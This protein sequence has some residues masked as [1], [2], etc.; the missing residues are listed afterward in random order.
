MPFTRKHM[1]EASRLG[2]LLDNFSMISTPGVPTDAPVDSADLYAALDMYAGT[3]KPLVLLI[4]GDGKLE[5]VIE[6]LSALHGD[7]S[8]KP[9]C[10]PYVNPITPLVLNRTT[11]DKMISSIR[12]NL[13]LMY[14]NYGMY[15]GSTPITGGGTLALLNAELLAGLVFSQLIREGSSMI[16]GSL[17]AAFNM[18]T[19]GS[20]AN[21]LA[22][23]R[24]ASHTEIASSARDARS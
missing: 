18:N 23:A 13:P 5:P 17:P 12:H 24:R 10:M 20:S 7:I 15:G 1:I 6:L 4:Y 14:S 9:F 22:R 11:S 3:D 2:Q 19:M 21:Q 16:L 8:S